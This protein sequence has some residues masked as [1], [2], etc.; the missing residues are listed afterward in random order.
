MKRSFRAKE[1]SEVNQQDIDD[2]DYAVL[3]RGK[4]CLKPQLASRDPKHPEFLMVS[5]NTNRIGTPSVHSS[6]QSS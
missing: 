6:P 3:K 4:G 1:Y 2:G 5:T